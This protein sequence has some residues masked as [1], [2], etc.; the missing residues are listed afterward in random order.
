MIEV[1][2]CEERENKAVSIL[3]Y[4]VDE[5]FPNV[6]KDITFMKFETPVGRKEKKEMVK[7]SIEILLEKDKGKEIS[8]RGLLEED[9]TA[10]YT[11]C[12]FSSMC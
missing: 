5:N 10:P 6:V 1:S 3:E 9:L 12:G 2:E 8:Q 4:V 11:D 7:E